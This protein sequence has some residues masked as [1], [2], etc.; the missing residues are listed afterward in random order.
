LAG[1]PARRGDGQVRGELKVQVVGTFAVRWGN[2]VLAGAD[3][4]SRKARLLLAL[5]A[6]E[7]GHWV[8]TDRITEALWTSGSARRPA[9]NLATLVSRLRRRFGPGLVEGGKTMYRLG[10]PV[11]VDLTDA[12]TLV[13]AAE[14][15]EE[16]SAALRSASQALDL[17][18]HGE[19]LGAEPHAKWAEP[20]REQRTILLRRARLVAANRALAA[21]DLRMAQDVATRAV[22]DDAFDEAAYRTLMVA[23]VASGEPA[24]ALIAYERLRGTLADELGTYPATSTRDLHVDILRGWPAVDAITRLRSTDSAEDRHHGSR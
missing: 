23:H 17:L 8:S 9:Q 15:D 10:G 4:G 18:E 14:R 6:V 5:L 22:A 24:R 11:T 2:S 1:W 19:V 7:Q 20:A 21:G 13:N 16:P 12:A 3:I